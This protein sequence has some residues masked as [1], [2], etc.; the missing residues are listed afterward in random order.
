M[1]RVTPTSPP[2]IESKQRGF[3]ECPSCGADNSP[4]HCDGAFQPERDELRCEAGVCICNCSDCNPQECY[5]CG[6]ELHGWSQSTPIPRSYKVAVVF[7]VEAASDV[8]AE[9]GVRS[10][11][12]TVLAPWYFIWTA[13]KGP[14]AEAEAPKV[15]ARD[16][17]VHA[18]GDGAT[19]LC[20]ARLRRGE[21]F[22]TLRAAIIDCPE[23]VKALS[24]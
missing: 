15:R 8:D 19:L 3:W 24:A 10:R 7:E 14:P 17:L 2:V 9:A 21:H 20:G 6:E 5:D 4:E 22:E 12:D 1:S 18:T 23:C 11:L 13:P 16:G